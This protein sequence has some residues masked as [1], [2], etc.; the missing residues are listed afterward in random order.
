MTTEKSRKR[1]GET[2][3]EFPNEKVEM[4]RSKSKRSKSKRSKQK[5]QNEKVEMERSKSKWFRK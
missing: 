2:K 5:G 1:K 4:E 3:N